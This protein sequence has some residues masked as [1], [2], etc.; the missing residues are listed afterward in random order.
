[1][2][3]FITA[4]LLFN[5]CC[6]VH[7]AQWALG[8][9][10]TG[11]NCSGA[12]NADSNSDFPL[13]L[14]TCVLSYRGVGSTANV[15]TKTVCSATSVERKGYSDD[16]CTV[17]SPDSSFNEKYGKPGCNADNLLLTCTAEHDVAVSKAWM[18]PPG[19]TAAGCT[20]GGEVGERVMA[21][22]ACHTSRDNT[23]VVGLKAV[24][25][26]NT[27]V[28]NKYLA[29]DCSGTANKFFTVSNTCATGYNANG[30]LALK[31]GCSSSSADSSASS[32][33]STADPST[34][35]SSPTPSSSTADPSA[36]STSP[37]ADYSAMPVISFSL[38][39]TLL[40]GR[41]VV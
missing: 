32:S 10:H 38:I 23:G 21:M 13:L 33:S 12:G 20:D 7:S 6:L 1:M 31:T 25:E 8:T 29:W 19:S 15:W 16:K 28:M 39:V 17:E 4:V 22:G 41:L 9:Y 34:S 11:S 40:L 3:D 5:G 35:S 24:C 36:P 2:N 18:L 14:N 37:T 27:V 30:W 26:G